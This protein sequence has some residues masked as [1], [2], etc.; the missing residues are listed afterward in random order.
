VVNAVATIDHGICKLLLI[1]AIAIMEVWRATP[2]LPE[3]Y[4]E[5]NI[6]GAQGNCSTGNFIVSVQ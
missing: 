4:G 6:K 1:Y 3:G 5:K 2:L